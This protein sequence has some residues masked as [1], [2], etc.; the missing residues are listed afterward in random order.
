M[1]E[2]TS[3]KA[4]NIF[5]YSMIEGRIITYKLNLQRE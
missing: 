5:K 2:A 3:L 1:M 4:K